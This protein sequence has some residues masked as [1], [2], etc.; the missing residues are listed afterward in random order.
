MFGLYPGAC[1]STVPKLFGR[2]SGDKILFVSSRRML[3]KAR[4]L[5]IILISIPFTTYEETSFTESAGRSFTNGFSRPKSFR[6][7][8]ETGPWPTPSRSLQS[9]T[10]LLLGNWY[11][12]NDSTVTRSDEGHVSGSKGYIFFYTRRHPNMA[13]LDKIRK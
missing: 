13:I 5:P 2:I 7:Y 6:D 8:R 1:F 9:A 12:F 3:L 4:K 10:F 11:N